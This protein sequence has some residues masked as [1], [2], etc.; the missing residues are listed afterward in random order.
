MKKIIFASTFFLVSILTYSQDIIMTNGSQSVCSGTFLDP[1]GTSNYANSSDYTMTLCSSTPGQEIRVEFTTFTLE[2]VTWDYLTIY[3]GSGTSGNLLVQ[4]S[5]DTTLIGAVVTST[6][7]GCLTFVF[8]SD[9]SVNYAGWE[10]QISCVSACQAFNAITTYNGGVFPDTI[11]LCV[12]EQINVTA[13]GNYPNNDID[14]HQSDTS[15][16]YTWSFGNNTVSGLNASNTYEIL[17]SYTLSLRVEDFNGCT[18]TE[19]YPVVVTCGGACA[20]CTDIQ[21]DD[22]DANICIGTFWDTGMG[23]DYANNE[24]Q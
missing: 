8:H 24:S 5:G 6:G 21:V 2:S 22:P 11:N 10:A 3:E 9:G 4:P 12:G 14:Y 13:T 15:S 16:I 7:S 20:P 19:T 1:G 18:Y 23:S 17:G